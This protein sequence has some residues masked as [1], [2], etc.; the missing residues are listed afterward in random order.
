MNELR[1]FK[2][3]EFDSPDKKGSGKNMSKELLIMLDNARSIAG[4]PFRITSGYRTKQ[5]NKKVGGVNGS[6]HTKGLAVDIAVLSGSMRYRIL[7]ALFSVGFN[8]IGISS[9]FIHCDIDEDKI[10]NVIWTY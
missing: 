7:D 10:Q 8:R 4:V 6:S 1:Y 5:H 2:L 3:E 9:N